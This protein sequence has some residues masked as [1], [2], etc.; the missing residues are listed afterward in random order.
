MAALGLCVLI[1]GFAVAVG[2]NTTGDIIAG[3]VMC[4]VGTLLIGGAYRSVQH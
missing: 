4:C 3:I 2:H 1:F